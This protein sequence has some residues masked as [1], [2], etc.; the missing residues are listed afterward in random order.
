MGMIWVTT[1]AVKFHRWLNA[2]VIASFLK[3]YHRH[4]FKYKLSI[5]VYHDDREVEFFQA[6]THLIEVVN[7]IPRTSDMSCEQMGDFIATRFKEGYPDRK[8][9]VEVSEDG[10]NGSYKEYSY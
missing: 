5:E 6:Q 2:P 8:L 9:I 4:L 10:E 7:Q 1:Q 3:D